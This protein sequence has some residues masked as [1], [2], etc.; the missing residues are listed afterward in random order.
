MPPACIQFLWPML[1][2]S[3]KL[4]IGLLWQLISIYDKRLFRG[5]QIPNW[6]TAIVETLGFLGFLTLFIGHRI[7]LIDGARYLAL[8][9]M[10]LPA[11]DSAVWIIL[12]Y[13]LFP[14]PLLTDV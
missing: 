1:I 11:D 4:I 9:E 6:A 8:G 2:K 14:I 12:W 13:F 10:L 5:R 3:H 7:A